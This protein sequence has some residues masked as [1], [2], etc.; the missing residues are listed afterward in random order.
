MIEFADSGF[1]ERVVLSKSVCFGDKEEIDGRVEATIT[2]E[3]SALSG[4]AFWFT[5]ENFTRS[6]V[7]FDIS[8]D[9]I[10]FG[11]GKREC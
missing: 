7:S 1:L 4:S 9:L 6:V 2:D 8:A 5:I 10:D 11:F 3:L